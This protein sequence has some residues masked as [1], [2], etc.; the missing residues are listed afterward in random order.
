MCTVKKILHANLLHAVY[1][2]Y[3]VMQIPENLLLVHLLC[4][5][6]DVECLDRFLAQVA[7]VS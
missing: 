5:S 1:A 2:G 7:Q 3:M 6:H 4:T